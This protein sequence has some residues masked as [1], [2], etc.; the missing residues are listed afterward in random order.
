MMK[1]RGQRGY[2][3]TRIRMTAKPHL[4]IFLQMSR[5]SSIAGDSSLVTSAARVLSRYFTAA[6][7]LRVN[8][9]TQ[10]S[11]CSSFLSLSVSLKGGGF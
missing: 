1:Q 3:R 7:E 2:G 11:V 4:W 6:A 9:C 5:K 8:V 10:D